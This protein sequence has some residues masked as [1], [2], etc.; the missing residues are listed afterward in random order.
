M[1]NTCF[2]DFPLTLHRHVSPNS[3][4]DSLGSDL[5]LSAHVT[6]CTLVQ[7]LHTLVYM[8]ALGCVSFIEEFESVVVFN[9]GSCFRLPSLDQ[10]CS[11]HQDSSALPVG[12]QPSRCV[13]FDV[14]FSVGAA[15]P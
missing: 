11:R 9:L 10:M 7:S 8:C 15:V 1:S 14:T 13:F 6:V 3:L 2:L 4:S 5:L 12:L